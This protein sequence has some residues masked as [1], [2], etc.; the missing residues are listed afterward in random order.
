[1]KSSVLAV[2]GL[3]CSAQAGFVRLPL[4]KVPLEQQ[5][6]SKN[7]LSMTALLQANYS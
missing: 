1:M 6:V 2:A 7:T 3:A 5:L 4:Q